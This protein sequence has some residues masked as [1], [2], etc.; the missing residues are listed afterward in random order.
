M[1]DD[2]IPVAELDA[3]QAQLEGVGLVEQYANKAGEAAMRLTAK[4]EHVANQAA[5][6]SEDD[7]A[8]LLEAQT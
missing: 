3:I 7:A 1:T 5:I 6:S 8:A 4:G 2:T